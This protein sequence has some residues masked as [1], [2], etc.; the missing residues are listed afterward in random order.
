MTESALTKKQMHPLRGLGVVWG[1]RPELEE[2]G[3]HPSPTALLW[4][5]QEDSTNSL[6]LGS[7]PIKWGNNTARLILV[8]GDETHTR[9]RCSHMHAD[10]VFTG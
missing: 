1:Q 8:C 9:M 3:S 4:V 2:P 7:A 6:S 10:Y 5:T